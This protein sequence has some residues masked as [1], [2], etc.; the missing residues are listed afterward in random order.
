MPP[1]DHVLTPFELRAPSGA[2]VAIEELAESSPVVL[3]LLEADRSPD[4]RMAMLR[5]LGRGVAA[6]GARLVVVSAGDC[7]AG[8]QLEAARIAEW[9]TDVGDAF[10]VLGAADR[11]LGRTRRRA[12]LFVV[13][14][15]LVLRFAFVAVEPDQWVP[16][17]FVL[18]RLNRLVTSSTATPLV[19]GFVVE[20]P[21]EEEY[22]EQEGL[23]GAEADMDRLVRQVGRELGLS[24]DELT[25][26]STASRFRDLGMVM[27]PDS[28]IAKDGPLSD[29]EWEVIKQH[30]ER[31]AEMLGAGPMLDDVRAIVR[32]SHEHLDGSGYPRALRGDEIPFGSRVLLAVE[33]YLAMQ[34]ERPYREILGMR[35]ALSELEAYI[36]RLYD[37]RVVAALRRVAGVDAGSEAAA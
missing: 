11:K 17:S 8:R 7:S 22:D 3:A 29:E 24:P 27:V 28:I 34:Q 37:P 1:L 2:T 20:T 30:P 15:G 23:S 9:F 10:R 14:R 33:S 16:A 18:S 6:A 12:G 5:E 36:G 4:P 25:K 32:A 26:L 21:A 31:S 19:Q 13:D 35:D